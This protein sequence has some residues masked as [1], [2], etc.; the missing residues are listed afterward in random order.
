[1]KTTVHSLPLSLLL[2]LLLPMLAIAARPIEEMPM[3]GG[4]HEPTVDR[5]P[6][7]SKDAANRGWKLYNEGDLDTAMKRFNQAWMFDR[8]NA[9]VYWGFGLVMGQ[10]ARKEDTKKN[11]EE[12]IRF[13]KMAVDK[14]KQ[15]GK[16]LGDLAF[17]HTIMGYYLESNKEDGK[18][19]F[20]KAREL[21][22][23]AYKLNPEFP[24][25]VANWSVFYFYTKD[26]D[27]AR[28][29]A[30]EATKMGYKFS[31]DYLQDLESKSK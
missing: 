16:I 10:R 14:D 29:K 6:G 21:Y 15:N 13:L 3:Y 5:N 19:N 2:L 8:E 11:L 1:M 25:I 17:S 4:E 30:D 9:E 26:Y 28:K 20:E 27:S 22:P 12:S 24:P 23:A 18:D 7:L 31:P